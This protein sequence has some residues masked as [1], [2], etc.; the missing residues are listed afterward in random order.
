M[1]VLIRITGS[2][3]W[4]SLTTTSTS[5][6]TLSSAWAETSV[7]DGTYEMVFPFVTFGAAVLY[8]TRLYMEG[9]SE[10]KF[11]SDENRGW[12]NDPSRPIFFVPMQMDTAATPDDAYRIQLLPPPDDAY[13][14]NFVYKVRPTYYGGS[15]GDKSAIPAMFDDVILYGTLFHCWDQ[16]DKQDR[17]GYWKTMYEQALMEARAEWAALQVTRLGGSGG[18]GDT[19]EDWP[20]AWS[21]PS[22]HNP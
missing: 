7:V 22:L 1:T 11:A 18:A 9:Y 21:D 2:D 10:L 6:G 8:P 12:F 4:F 15:A 3:T 17:S 14:I 20:V 19:Y 16:E 5:A 13:T